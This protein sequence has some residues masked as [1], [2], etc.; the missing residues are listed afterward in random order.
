MTDKERLT[1]EIVLTLYSIL[2]GS[3]ATKS[4]TKFDEA[5]EKV[6]EILK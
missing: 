1:Q 5:V 4:G 3:D 2:L 6:K